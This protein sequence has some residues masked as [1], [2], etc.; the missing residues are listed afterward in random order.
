MVVTVRMRVVVSMFVCMVVIM[1]MP[2]GM[3]VHV[4]VFV[5]MPFTSVCLAMGSG[6]FIE[7]QRLDRHRHRPGGHANAT[8][9]HEVKA[10]QGHAIDDQD[11]AVHALVF[12]QQMAQIVRNV[13]VCHHI[14]GAVLSQ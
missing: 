2:L 7:N 12:F 11:F 8:E 5:G 6:V 13:T 4:A 3:A 1:R 10:P 14:N 9:V